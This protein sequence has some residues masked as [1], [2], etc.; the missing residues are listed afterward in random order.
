MQRIDPGVDHPPERRGEVAPGG[1][2]LALG[3]ERVAPLGIAAAEVVVDVPVVEGPGER[4]G[5]VVA[6]HLRRDDERG[7]DQLH[8]RPVPHSVDALADRS[9]RHRAVGER[10]EQDLG[11]RREEAVADPGR[12]IEVRPHVGGLDL[13]ADEA[14][15]AG[16]VDVAVQFGER[17]ELV[18]LGDEGRQLLGGHLELGRDLGARRRQL[19]QLEIRAGERLVLATN[20]PFEGALDERGDH[21]LGVLAEHVAR[22]AGGPAGRERQALRELGV[23]TRLVE[24]GGLGDVLVDL[25]DR[26]RLGRVDRGGRS[27]GGR[28]LGR[29][30]HGGGC[31]GRGGLDG[32]VR[33]SRR[34]VGRRAGSDGGRRGDPDDQQV[35][36]SHVL[37]VHAVGGFGSGRRGCG[38]GR[39]S[40]RTTTSSR[41]WRAV[42]SR[43]T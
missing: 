23:G 39:P 9:V 15:G 28:R 7:A 41:W 33:R 19:L 38:A 18:E 29:R 16:A 8:R 35:S 30:S 2:A 3:D 11:A 31:D 5:M 24:R 36:M 13:V 12:L 26:A 21:T 27:D 43:P 17:V 42:P 20:R 14:L 10:V 22:V 37:H 4:L 34:L 6:D 32:C 25:L 1:L 40:G